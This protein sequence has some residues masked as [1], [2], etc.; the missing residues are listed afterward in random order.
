[1]TGIE[2]LID[3]NQFGIKLGLENM[4]SLCNYFD[5]PQTEYQIIHI[6]GTNGKGST[7]IM[8]TQML[9]NAG[10]QVASYTSP[11]VEK[12][13]ENFKVNL[14]DIDDIT[15]NELSLKV[16]KA[17][18]VCNLQATHYEAC[19]MIMFLYA[20]L[21]EV[22]FLVLEVGLGGRYDA[23]NVVKADLSIITN[24][25][26]DHTHILGDTLEKIAYEKCGIIK[27]NPVIIGEK[28]PALIDC[29]QEISNQI[30]Y[31]YQ[32][33]EK[34]ELDYK[35]FITKATIN[36][37]VFENHLFG[38]HQAYNMA[39]VYEVARFFKIDIEH[40]IQMCAHINWPSRFEIVNK[41]P[42]IILDGAHNEGA[43]HQ[44]A[45]A[46]KHYNKDQVQMIFSMLAD[47]DLERLAPIIE[48][49]TNNLIITDLKQV[50][51]ER[52]MDS[53]KIF[54]RINVENKQLIPI[55]TN[56]FEQISDDFI[57][58]I[59]CG[60]FKIIEEYHKWSDQNG[61]EIN[62]TTR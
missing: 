4:Q 19:T 59:I 15:L 14:T 1:M 5:N 49:M 54:V 18:E 53:R 27:G 20:K 12:L 43:M 46:L 24:I 39:I 62:K 41:Q 45:L 3:L 55:P 26:L 51:P 38:Y 50:E 22:D 23:T 10:Y 13:N 28:I 33:I 30:I 2:Q 42:L 47:K 21:K 57:V 32:Q 6:A 44:L 11:Y 60:S 25:S 9:I 36:N 56:A 34:I 40:Y 58:N 61:N 48:Q 7:S 37:Q 16:L 35:H 8:T 17:I 29:A 52:A 31:S